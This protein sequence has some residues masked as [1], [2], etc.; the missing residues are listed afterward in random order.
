MILE[1]GLQAILEDPQC[2]I[3]FVGRHQGSLGI[4]VNVKKVRNFTCLSVTFE[5]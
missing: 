4:L 3:F 1:I 5:T 2:Q